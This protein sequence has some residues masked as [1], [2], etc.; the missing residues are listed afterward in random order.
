[1]L[2]TLSHPRFDYGDEVRVTRN[3]RND[4]TY[5]GLRTGTLLIRR[6]ST[7]IVR[8]IGTFLQDQ[9]IYTVHFT[10]QD[11]IVGCRDTE[12]LSI[13]A[14]W[15]PSRFEFGERVSARI[16]LGIKG[17]VVA[18]TGAEGEVFKVIRDD[19]VVARYGTVVYHVRFPGHT[20]MVPE[21]ALQPLDEDGNKDAF[22]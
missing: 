11:L 3:I 18:E 10:E 13:N 2:E 19:E 22:P 14:P 16:P 9:V 4:G 12:L 17:E 15:T 20:L 7:G 21:T 6:G 5:P 1:M 8:D